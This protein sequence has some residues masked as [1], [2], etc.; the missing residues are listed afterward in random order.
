MLQVSESGC[1]FG[2]VLVALLAGV[3]CALGCNDPAGPD[4]YGNWKLRCP[5]NASADTNA[6]F[7]NDA[8]ADAPAGTDA[9]FGEGKI[10]NC[11]LDNFS[12]GKPVEPTVDF[13]RLIQSRLHQGVYR[14]IPGDVLEFRMPTILRMLTMETTSNYTDSLGQVGTYA[15]RVNSLGNISLPIIG[16]IQAT[17]KSVAEIEEEII[18]AYYPR[19]VVNVP[20]VVGMVTQY[21]TGQLSIVGAVINPGIYQCHHDEMSLVALMMKAGGVVKEGAAVIRVQRAGTAGVSEPI[22]LPVK[23]LNIPF[24]DVALADGDTVEV[25]R[26]NPQVFTVIGLVNRSGTFVYPPGVKYT[27]LQALAFAGGVND[28]A[29][30]E[31]ARIYRQDDRGNII[32]ASF[33]LRGS[34]PVDAAS[35]II[36]PG[37]V[38]AVEHNFSTRSRVLLAQLLRITAGVNVYA[39]YRMDTSFEDASSR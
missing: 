3:L 28:I 21:C 33:K 1:G 26:L 7:G 20:S 24:A 18:N 36:K 27:L 10:S 12:Q 19:Y 16:D 13:N 25:E 30:P 2:G 8:R 22:V 15:C 11:S 38:V 37:D 17:G 32:S 14:L 35:T 5:A 29:A 31:Y 6:D 39:T 23:G 4:G 9:G 34:M